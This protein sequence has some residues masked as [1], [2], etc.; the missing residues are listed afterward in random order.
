MSDATI[1]GRSRP[2]AGLGTLLSDDRLV[3]RAARGGRRALAEIY[4]RYH[5]GLYRLCLATVGNTSDAQDALQNTMVR[6]LRALPGETRRIQLKPW[7]YR[8]AHNESIEVLRRR[9]NTEPLDPELSAGRPAL[10]EEAATRER[11]RR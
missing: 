4:G 6:V 5:Q 2:S 11:L 1:P 3:R 10:A 8:I 7:L 9:R